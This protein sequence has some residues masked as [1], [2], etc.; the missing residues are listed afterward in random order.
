MLVI[1]LLLLLVFTAAGV[2]APAAAR[3]AGRCWR[4][5]LA[6]PLATYLDLLPA[7]PKVLEVL[8]TTASPGAVTGTVLVGSAALLG[9]GR[10]VPRARRARSI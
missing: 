7:E 1:G 4:L 9:F 5:A 6:A 8:A 3:Q 2:W 10:V